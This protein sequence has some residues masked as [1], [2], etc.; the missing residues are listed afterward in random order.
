M[1]HLTIV[2]TP[3]LEQEA[4]MT[5][6]CRHLANAMLTVKDE[7]DKQV[8]PTG[9]TRV[10]AWPAKHFAVADGS[11]EF[12]FVYLNLRMGKGRSPQTIQHAGEVLTAHTHAFFEALFQQRGLEGRN[13]GITFQIDEGHEAFDAKHSNI[14]PLFAA[15]R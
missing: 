6:L 12:A 7:K 11:R 5:G 14:H 3:N 2:Y 8:F 15:P 10:L 4:D 1:P 13:M 9:G